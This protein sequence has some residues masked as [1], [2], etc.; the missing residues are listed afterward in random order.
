MTYRGRFIRIVI[1]A[2]DVC[3]TLS[4][5]EL[6]KKKIG[7]FSGRGIVLLFLF[8]F[9]F[10]GYSIKEGYT[11]GHG[12]V[13]NEKQQGWQLWGHSVHYGTQNQL[14]P[15]ELVPLSHMLRFEIKPLL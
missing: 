13:D 12:T 14:H 5:L 9:F 10:V 3:P 15:S 6:Q 2:M 8:C 4:T 7:T 1:G 11:Y